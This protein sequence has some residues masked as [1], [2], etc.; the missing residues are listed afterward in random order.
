MTL[1]ALVADD[2]VVQLATEPFDVVPEWTWVDASG[3][4]PAPEVGWTATLAQNTWSFAPVPLSGA[5]V[6]AALVASAAVALDASDR[7]VIRCYEH[8][9]PVPAVWATYRAALRGIVSGASSPTTLPAVPAY[10]AGT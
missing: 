3:I 9:V 10:P 4:S 2:K 5:D 8:A 1:L 6:H 7:T